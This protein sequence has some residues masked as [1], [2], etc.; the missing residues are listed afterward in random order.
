MSGTPLTDF[1][2]KKSLEQFVKTPKIDLNF[3]KNIKNET[4]FIKELKI[5]RSFENHRFKQGDKRFTEFL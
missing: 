4:Q 2:L 5:R 3:G 1:L